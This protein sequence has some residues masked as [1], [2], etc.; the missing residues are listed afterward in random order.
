[1]TCKQ[2]LIPVRSS[3]WQRNCSG[4][5]SNWPA[6]P[7]KTPMPERSS[8]RQGMASSC[9]GLQVAIADYRIA[10]TSHSVFASLKERGN[11]NDTQKAVIARPAGPWQSGRCEEDCFVVTLLA[12]TSHS[13]FASL[14]ERGNHNDTQKAVIARPAGRGNLGDAKKIASSL[15]SSQ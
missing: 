14:K 15:L 9:L 8:F 1:M 13:V 4:K 6:P 12:M 11:H 10:M 7:D 5:D 2:K 3:S